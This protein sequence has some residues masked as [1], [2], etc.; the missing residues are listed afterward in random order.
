MIV[1]YEEMMSI[2]APRPDEV[3]ILVATGKSKLERRLWTRR[4]FKF[5]ESRLGSELKPQRFGS[6]YLTRSGIF[7][8]LDEFDLAPLPVLSSL[9]AAPPV[10]R[11]ALLDAHLSSL[12]LD[13]GASHGERFETLHRSLGSVRPFGD[14]LRAY[15]IRHL[16]DRP[17]LRYRSVLLG[18]PLPSLMAYHLESLDITGEILELSTEEIDR[19]KESF[20][21]AVRDDLADVRHSLADHVLIAHTTSVGGMYD[22]A[23]G[24]DHAPNRSIRLG[25]AHSAQD[26]QLVEKQRFAEELTK[27]YA[28]VGLKIL[29]TAAAI[30]IDEVRIRETIPLHKKIA[31]MLQ[32]SADHAW[33][34]Y[35][36]GEPMA[37]LIV[38]PATVLLDAPSAEPTNFRHRG[39]EDVL[40]TKAREDLV[41]PSHAIRSGENGFFTVA[42]AEALY[43]VMRVASASELG[44]VLATVALF[45]DD[46]SS[47]WFDENGVCYYTE[48]D[49]SRQVFDFLAQP[50]LRQAQMNGL[51]PMALQDLGSAKHQA[52]LHTL[53]LL[54]LLHRLRT[55]DVD[56]IPPYIEHSR[57]DSRTFFQQ[58]SRA[59]TFED[60]DSW[61]TNETARDLAT[62]VSANAPADLEQLKPFRLHGHDNLFPDKALA[63]QEIFRDVLRAVWTIP[64]LGT[65]II[66]ERDER[67]CIRTGFFVAPLDIL[68]TS[69]D[70]VDRWF[71]KRLERPEVNCTLEDLRDHHFA[72]A[73]FIDVRPH[74][75]L[76]ASKNDHAPDGVRVFRAASE[77]AL[78]DALAALP[79][80]SFFSTCGLLA[81][82]FRLR[83]LYSVLK[84]A[85]LQLGTL[86]EF[87]WQMPRD[88][89]G[90]LLVLPGAVEAM[91]MVSE[92]VEKTTGT[93]RLDGLWGY[94]RRV[95]PD[96]AAEIRRQYPSGG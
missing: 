47:P 56:A 82:L 83:C 20:L 13:S 49:N 79:P 59:L 51:D 6:G 31:Q 55:L 37:I 48:T 62:L 17:D 12:G 44:F 4:F 60:I 27:L 2:A 66:F 85:V 22:E 69:T 88:A 11:R 5:M 42:N 80:Y 35:N 91:R 33:H 24:N 65:P 38:R 32:Q 90:H 77:N 43:R 40:R 94:E 30:G 63:R 64:S 72:A 8:N 67:T 46:P 19:L 61:D 45:G 73:G 58:H 18:I 74:A 93:E 71:R 3:P 25:F 16:S 36:T 86:Q 84:E 81:V 53:G 95:P 68:M 15:R 78:R 70:G 26:R 54:I 23:I 89:N 28:G 9:V 41:R 29:I 96:R 75:I 7:M 39:D 50:A 1:T 76:S 57:F 34:P 14:F 52:E 87:R 92:G 21:V 10:E